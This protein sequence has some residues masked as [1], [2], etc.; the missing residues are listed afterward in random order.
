[1]H[2][3]YYHALGKRWKSAQISFWAYRMR[4]QPPP[5]MSHVLLHAG[6]GDVMFCKLYVRYARPMERRESGML[7][8][9]FQ[10]RF[11]GRSG[12]CS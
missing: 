9:S 2:L 8:R 5:S 10:G 7:V 11:H 3:G 12:G 4:P 6:M 1:M